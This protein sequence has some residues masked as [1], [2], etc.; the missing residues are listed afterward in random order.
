MFVAS[1]RGSNVNCMN[2]F[3]VWALNKLFKRYLTRAACPFHPPMRQVMWDSQVNLGPTLNGW[4]Y[5]FLA[6]G[7]I[8][9]DVS[10]LSRRTQKEIIVD[11]VHPV[12]DFVHLLRWLWRDQR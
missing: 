3:I 12:L 8:C 9:Q 4:A 1:L 11:E 5:C 10:L 6:L 7:S 2:L